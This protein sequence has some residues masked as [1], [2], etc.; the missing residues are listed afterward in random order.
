VWIGLIKLIHPERFPHR[1][2]KIIVIFNH[3]SLIEPFF[4]AC[5]F[6][7]SYLWHHKLAPVA[8]IDKINMR[9]KDFF[10]SRWLAWIRPFCIPVDRR[11]STNKNAIEK[12]IAVLEKDKILIWSPEGGRTTTGGKLRWSQSKK[13]CIREKLQ[14]TG[15]YLAQ[16]TGAKILLVWFGWKKRNTIRFPIRDLLM[17]RLTIK[18]GGQIT[19]GKDEDKK[20]AT[21]Q[22]R[23]ALLKLSD[24]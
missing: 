3:P 15:A 8:V 10:G 12:M 9:K 16:S 11:N 22:M 24:E 23:D 1:K 5:L 17:G 2:G 7:Q 20:I 13:H 18:I 19:V 14:I 21:E 6:G 4:V